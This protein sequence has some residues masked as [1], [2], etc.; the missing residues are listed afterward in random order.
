VPL[1][2]DDPRPPYLQIMDALREAIRVGEFTPGSR[3][4]STNELALRYGVARNTVRS[5]V[6]KLSEEGLLVPRHGTG[7]FVR[8]SLPEPLHT[9][10]DS[11]RIDAVVQELTEVRQEVHD[12]RQRMNQLESL[13]RQQ[14][15][16][17][18]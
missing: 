10:S 4:P 16:Q 1:P 11:S 5:A 2:P 17:D 18:V 8:S 7:V 15:T 14:A 3:I 9:G 6:G 13:L 12:L